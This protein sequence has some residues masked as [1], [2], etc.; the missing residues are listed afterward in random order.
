MPVLTH[1]CK[2]DVVGELSLPPPP[3]PYLLLSLLYFFF[4]LFVRSPVSLSFHCDLSDRL[5]NMYVYTWNIVSHKWS[6]KAIQFISPALTLS[7]SSMLT[8]TLSAIFD[9]CKCVLCVLCVY[10]YYL[11]LPWI[12]VDVVGNVCF[13][14]VRIFSLS[15]SSL[16]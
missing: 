15:L 10:D 12:L 11:L 1:S 5:H 14:C 2:C 4:R 7:L 6:F 3:L 13:W 9:L 16:L 8:L